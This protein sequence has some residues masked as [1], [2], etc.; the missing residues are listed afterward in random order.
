VI[1]FRKPRPGEAG[2]LSLS[3]LEDARTFREVA[4]AILRE[5]L[6]RHPGAPADRLYDEL[7]SRTVRRGLFERHDFDALLRSVAEP[8][9]EPLKRNLFEDEPPNLWGTHEQ[10]RW[11]LVETADRP[12]PSES[13]RLDAAAARLEAFMRQRL[14]ASAEAAGAEAGDAV[15]GAHYSDLFEQYLAVRDK[16]RRLLQ[17][18]LPEYFLRTPEGAW[19]P[20]AN[21]EE[22]LALEGLRASGALRRIKRYANALLEGAP[23]APRDRPENAATAAEWLRQCRRAGLYAQGRA[24]Y[25]KGGFDFASLGEEA[26]LSVDEDYQ[27]CVRRSG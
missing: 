13:A 1:N 27:L 20:P 17:D 4:Q 5:A 7:V 2:Q 25:E 18:W 6:E 24:L 23:P 12:D 8:V 22:R 16:P 15:P 3:G 10:V 9:R 19:R 14:G 26:S 11:Y 21:E